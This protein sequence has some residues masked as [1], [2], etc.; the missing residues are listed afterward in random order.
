MLDLDFGHA[1]GHSDRQRFEETAQFAERGQA[2]RDLIGERV[3]WTP[4]VPQRHTGQ[5]RDKSRGHARKQPP[6]RWILTIESYAAH[7]VVPP[8]Q[9]FDEA[10]DVTRIA[11]QVDVESHQVTPGGM[12]EASGERGMLSEVR[13][14]LDDPHA[15]IGG[16]YRSERVERTVGGAI[17]DI[18]DFGA[19]RH[20]IQNGRERR[21]TR[22]DQR[23]AVEDG[24]DDGDEWAVGHDVGEM[25]MR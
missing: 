22:G 3:Q 11:L 18:N 17:V 1:P 5:P 2:A 25:R 23:R 10:W 12:L 4:D 7:Q 21:L 6:C 20:L 19:S 8:S 13:G 16:L 15:R 9:W 24:H 14:E